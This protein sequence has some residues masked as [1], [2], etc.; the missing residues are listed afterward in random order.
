MKSAMC[1]QGYLSRLGFVP[2]S[3]L[4]ASCQNGEEVCGVFLPCYS[5]SIISPIRLTYSLSS[6]YVPCLSCSL[7]YSKRWT[8]YSF[9]SL[10]PR[11]SFSFC[12]FF[13][14]S[15]CDFAISF[16]CHTESVIAVIRARRTK[17]TQ[18]MVAIKTLLPLVPPSTTGGGGGVRVLQHCAIIIS[19][20][21]LFCI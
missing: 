15:L 5:L 10:R 2:P 11:S 21:M 14:A 20:F 7:T 8:W 19:V 13:S 9:F 12:R 18:M 1:R 17:E 3:C 4:R 16:L 6:L